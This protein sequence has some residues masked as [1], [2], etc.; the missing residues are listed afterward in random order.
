[1]SDNKIGSRILE[2]L[3]AR[4]VESGRTL[5]IREDTYFH[6]FEQNPPEQY[7]VFTLDIEPRSSSE[8]LVSIPLVNVTCVRWLIEALTR[9]EKIMTTKPMRTLV[10]DNGHSFQGRSRSVHGGGDSSEVEVEAKN[11]FVFSEPEPYPRVWRGYEVDPQLDPSWDF[12]HDGLRGRL[13][14]WAI[15]QR[16]ALKSAGDE[17]GLV[18]LE[19]NV[20]KLRTRLHNL[21]NQA[22]GAC[23]ESWEERTAQEEKAWA[24]VIGESMDPPWPFNEHTYYAL[25]AA[26]EHTVTETDD[27]AFHLTAFEAEE[28][29]D[30]LIKFELTKGDINNNNNNKICVMKYSKAA[31]DRHLAD[32]GTEGTVRAITYL[33]ERSYARERR[34]IAKQAGIARPS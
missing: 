23:P 24:F 16:E 15:T 31:I 34:H 25:R 1:M 27:L 5:S 11:G 21:V 9:V 33:V 30:V 19:T 22:P 3:Y 6:Q 2:R 26:L 32:G 8:V 20:A 13:W 12:L 29:P 17:A 10:R 14:K 4:Y 18:A 28:G 7:R